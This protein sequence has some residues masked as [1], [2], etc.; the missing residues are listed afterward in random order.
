MAL[1]PSL[2]LASQALWAIDGF[3]IS[4]CKDKI[5]LRYLFAGN[6]TH[7]GTRMSVAPGGVCCVSMN[8]IHLTA[9]SGMSRMA[10]T[11]PIASYLPSVS[12]SSVSEMS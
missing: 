9:P 6:I 10:M 5:F 12:E 7:R 8:D 3:F 1:P 2:A 11:H 4:P